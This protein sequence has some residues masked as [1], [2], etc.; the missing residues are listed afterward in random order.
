M[1]QVELYFSEDAIDLGGFT[2]LRNE[3]EA[4]DLI[5]KVIDK[6]LSSG[7]GATINVLQNLRDV[8]LDR[9]HELGKSNG[10]E[11][12]IFRD[13]N[14]DK[15]KCLLEWGVKNGVKTNLDIARK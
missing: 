1:L 12:R 7:K 10:E 3:L 14:S 6:V 5:L 13:S 9:I 4:L 15:E 2:S 11:T 8:T